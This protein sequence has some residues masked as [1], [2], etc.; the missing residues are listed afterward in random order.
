VKTGR[1]ISA[2]STTGWGDWIH[3]NLWLF[4]DGLLRVRTSLRSTIANGVIR[5]TAIPLLTRAFAEEEIPILANAHSTNLWI[6]SSSI[7]STALRRGATTS[8]L[9]LKLT[10]GREI[11]LLWLRRDPAEQALRSALAEWGLCDVA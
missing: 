7:V 1:L 2:S 9:G 5:T 11:K 6:P 3:G 10:D 8:S 4:P